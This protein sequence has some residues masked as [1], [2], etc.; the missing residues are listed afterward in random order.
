M[1]IDPRPWMIDVSQHQGPNI[2]FQQVYGE[3]YR[4]AVVKMSE[5]TGYVDPY[6]ISN[7]RRAKGVMPV[8]GAYHF[9]WGGMSPV[10]QANHFLN[11]VSGAMNPANALL[12]V[13]VEISGNMSPGQHP[14]LDDVKRF[15]HTLQ[16]ALPGKKL[17]IYS[18]Y[19][20]RGQMGNPDIDRLGLAREPI[21]WD[22]HYFATRIDWGSVLYEKVPESYWDT[23]AYGGRKADILQFADTGRLRQFPNGIDVN[24]IRPTLEELQR[25]A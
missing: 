18:G 22:A 14:T 8:V 1:S 7:L 12:F 19:Y 21:I 4:G 23:N 17:G 20:W 2:D 13:D 25:W 11:Q 5:G 6:G 16:D 24:A 9:L 10:K 3:G 15:M